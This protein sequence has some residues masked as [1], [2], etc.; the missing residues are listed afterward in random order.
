MTWIQRYLSYSDLIE[1]QSKSHFLSIYTFLRTLIR[2]SRDTGDGDSDRCSWCFSVVL[3]FDLY[4]AKAYSWFH[5]TRI[6]RINSWPYQIHRDASHQ[7]CLFRNERVN[8][9]GR[10]TENSS[11]PR[12]WTS[13]NW[14]LRCSTTRK[15]DKTT[16]RYVCLHMC[17]YVY[18]YI[19]CT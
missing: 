12:P 19:I 11:W 7:A 5:C 16:Y 2:T 8:F 3:D 18:M 13:Q 1:R 10:I 15:L 14:E 17:I 6:S 4:H 9:S